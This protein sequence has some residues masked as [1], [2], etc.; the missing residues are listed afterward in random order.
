MSVGDGKCK[1]LLVFMRIFAEYGEGDRNDI[2]R[3]DER[4]NEDKKDGIYLNMLGKAE[5][6]TINTLTP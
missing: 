2:G 3:K 1:S 6:I 4:E 5:L